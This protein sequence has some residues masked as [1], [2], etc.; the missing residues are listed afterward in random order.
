M[1]QRVL[2]QSVLSCNVGVA[3]LVAA[4]VVSPTPAGASPE[5]DEAVAVARGA[6]S[7]GLL[8]HNA[9]VEQAADIVNRSTYAYL[10]K[11][12]FDVPADAP[13]PTAVLRDLGIPTDKAI[14]LQG[15]GR[16]TADAIKGALLQG[17]KAIPDCAYTEI[18][19]SILFEEQSGYA[20]VVAIL[21]GP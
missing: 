18:G 16:T 4:V 2:R 20:L 17:Y 5:V 8:R 21:V 6:S 9:T 7:C 10:S 19:T 14:S 15:A 11:D 1:L 13:H 12:S 3:L